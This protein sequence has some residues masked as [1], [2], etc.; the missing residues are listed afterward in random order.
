MILDF[1]NNLESGDLHACQCCQI[2]LYSCELEVEFL[3]HLVGSLN[4]SAPLVCIH[5]SVDSYR[6]LKLHAQNIGKKQNQ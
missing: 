6:N 1:A 3:V 5:L 2:N 4:P